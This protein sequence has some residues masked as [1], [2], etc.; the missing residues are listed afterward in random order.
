M[1]N[2]RQINGTDKNRLRKAYDNRVALYE[3]EMLIY[4]SEPLSLWELLSRIRHG[5]VVIAWSHMPHTRY[6]RNLLKERAERE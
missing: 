3:G 4:G 5:L 1:S 2:Q 6:Y